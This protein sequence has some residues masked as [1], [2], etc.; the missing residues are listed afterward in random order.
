MRPKGPN[1]RRFNEFPSVTSD[2]KVQTFPQSQSDGYEANSSRISAQ[3]STPMTAM[4]EGRNSLVSKDQ[5]GR[6]DTRTQQGTI[7]VLRLL[8]VV[9][10]LGSN[11]TVNAAM[12]S[13]SD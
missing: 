3:I 4:L 9:V 13:L 5:L 11:Y 2:S 10:G 6:V 7:R 1:D 12:F 8:K